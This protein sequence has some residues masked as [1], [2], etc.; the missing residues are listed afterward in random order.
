MKGAGASSL[1]G[2][3]GANRGG[4]PLAAG[5][6]PSAGSAGD[7]PAFRPLASTLDDF[8]VPGTQTGD[9]VALSY[10]D[11]EECA[12]CHAFP[13]VSSPLNGWTG[14]L[15]ANSA[16]D[17]VFFAALSLANHDTPAAGAFCLRCH[18]PFSTASGSV[19]DVTG[20]SLSA[21][22]QEGVTC[23]FC[24]SM[25]DPIFDADTSV[26]G[27]DEVL[28]KLDS[29]PAHYGNAMFVLDPAAVRRGPFTPEFAGHPAHES[30]FVRRSDFCGTCHDVSN[31]LL[32]HESDGQY[33]YNA[34]GMAA[35]DA[36]PATQFPLSRTYTEWK[37][38]AFAKGGVD[39]QGRFAGDGLVAGDVGQSGSGSGG[40]A[41][42]GGTVGGGSGGGGTGASG[43]TQAT[44][45]TGGNAGGGGVSLGG[46]SGA[47]GTSRELISTCQDCH[48]PRAKGP[49]CNQPQAQF[50]LEV[51][52][53]EFAGASAWVLEI[54]GRLYEGNPDVDTIALESGKRRAI[55]MLER[56]A[57]VEASV[58]GS[59][60]Q[61]RVYNQ[62]GHK[63]PTGHAQGRR[64]WLNV[65]LYDSEKQLLGEYGG[66]DSDSA[67]LD[68]AT[69]TV[70]ERRIGLSAEAAERAAQLP[71]E[72]L[73][74]TLADTILKDNRIP[75]RGYARTAYEAA[76][77]GVIG[78]DYADGQYW[79]DLSFAIAPNTRYVKVALMYQS[80]SAGQI[81]GWHDLN[82]TDD[83]G[84]VLH[85]L[86]LETEKAPPL[87]IASADITLSP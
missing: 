69:T 83:R 84:Q 20:E 43:G 41:Q 37:L 9:V 13:S 68:E 58:N 42:S 70:F 75:P 81:E 48:M 24:H 86:W 38:S 62:T 63:L 30:D 15:M 76:G 27:D 77:A 25:V 19:A 50:R 10:L 52:S 59:E 31:P 23:H 60:L 3:G 85:D 80:V 51:P 47:T 1:E 46:T 64:M 8:H 74:M 65:R 61:V 82:T 72:T 67:E 53:H 79:A 49:A 2:D 66:Y 22:D 71:G 5:G 34:L 33:R 44:G 36:D 35:P 54:I 73:R 18:V 26:K 7:G 40:D 4:S 12:K 29:A 39:M 17:P 14:S 28:A 57:S 78:A 16:R 21:R 87:R 45:G 55:D 32:T 11:S 56:A 6:D